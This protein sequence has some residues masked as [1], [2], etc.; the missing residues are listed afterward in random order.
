MEAGDAMLC[1]RDGV[2]AISPDQLDEALA[3]AD[4]HMKRE[5]FLVEGLALGKSLASLIAASGVVVSSHAADRASDVPPA[6]S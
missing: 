2:M 3:F 4:K 1:D 5:N 6:A